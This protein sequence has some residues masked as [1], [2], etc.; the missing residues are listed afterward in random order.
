[1]RRHHEPRCH[2][3]P[4]VRSVVVL[5]L[6]QYDCAAVRQDVIPYFRWT[7]WGRALVV[8]LSIAP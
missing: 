6:G 4:C 2:Q 3:H 5:A 8:S 7:V 1:M